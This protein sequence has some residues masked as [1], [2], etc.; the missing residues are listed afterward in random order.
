[1]LTDFLKD[2]NIIIIG[3]LILINIVLIVLVVI[4]HL[5]LKRFLKGGEAKDF[6]DTLKHVSDN[7]DDLQSFRKELEE[8]LTSVEKRLK[9]SVQKVNTVRFNPFKG[10]GGGGNQSFSTAFLNEEGDGVVISSLYSRDHV[11]VFSK[12]VKENK[13]EY[14]LTDE[15]REAISK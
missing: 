8:Y 4:F 10:T 12:P 2:P 14:E 7:L 1:M 11:S 5:R 9:K 6:K 15:E 3:I 13:S